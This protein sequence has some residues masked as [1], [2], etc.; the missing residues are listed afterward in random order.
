M[1]VVEQN[2]VR[3]QVS[4]CTKTSPPSSPPSPIVPSSL[5]L[6]GPVIFQPNVIVTQR[7]DI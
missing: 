7:E 2:P 4:T 1:E 5:L 6:A 3:R